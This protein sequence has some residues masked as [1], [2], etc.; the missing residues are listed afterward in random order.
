[1]QKSHFL[2]EE[3]W[4]HETVNKTSHLLGKKIHFQNLVIKNIGNRQQ[5]CYSCSY[6]RTCNY[7][8][9]EIQVNFVQQY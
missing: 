7:F 6:D 2:L 8:F 3:I 1:M 9:S 4:G 5:D